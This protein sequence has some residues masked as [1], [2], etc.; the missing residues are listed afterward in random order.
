MSAPPIPRAYRL[1]SP[2]PRAYR[3]LFTT[4]EPLLAT[5]GAIQAFFYPEALVSSTV[6]TVPYSPSLTPL[7]TQMT[8]AWLMLSFH[9]FVTLRSDGLKDDVRV[10]RH[11]LAA[12][13]ISDAFYTASLIQSIGPA[14]FFDP[15]RWDVVNAVTVITTVVPFLG[16]LCFLAGV[17]LSK[18][19]P[20]RKQSEKKAQAERKALSE[21]QGQSEKKALAEKQEQIEKKEQDEKREHSEREEQ[22]EKKERGE[23]RKQ[24]E[25]RRRSE[26]KKQ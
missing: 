3:L 8:G 12:S 7:F 18:T 17:G 5:G 20:V 13:A 9:D 23:R 4:F 15:R 26:K 19:G 6:P 1:T 10:W 16:K 21:R 22:G 25:R 14:R 11:T 2:I 24:G